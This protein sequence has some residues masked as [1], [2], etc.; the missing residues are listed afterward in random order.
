G[1]LWVGAG[2]GDKAAAIIADDWNRAGMAATPYMIPAARRSDRQYE[3]ERPGLLC[4]VRAGPTFE[5]GD[6]ATIKAINSA[7]T[8]WQGLNYGAYRNPKADAIVDKLIGTLDP[9][10][11]LSISQQL[12]QEYTSDVALLPL[13]WE[14]FPMLMVQGVKGQRPHFVRPTDTA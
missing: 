5:S 9:R 11:R 12:V 10:Q 14:V 3:A 4:C 13:W 7:A 1:E 6:E 8:N 2:A